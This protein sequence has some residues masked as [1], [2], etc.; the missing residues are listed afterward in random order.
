MTHGENIKVNIYDIKS[1]RNIAYSINDC[2][3]QILAFEM[4]ESFHIEV[5][6]AYA[7]MIRTYIMRK[8]HLFDGRGC[9]KYLKADLCNDPNHCIGFLPLDAI[10][11]DRKQELKQ[12]VEETANKIITF[13]GKMI[14]PYYHDTCGGATENSERIFGNIIQYA[15]RVLCDHC[16]STSPHWQ[17]SIEFTIEE[18]EEKLNIRFPKLSPFEGFAIDQ[19]LY[20]AERDQQGRIVQIKV[21]DQLIDG[22]DFQKRLGLPSTRIGW[23]P[24]GIK[25][26]IQG[27]GDGVGLCQYGAQGLALKGKN[28]EEILRYY[29]TGVKIEKKPQWSIKIPLKEKIILIDVGHGG[30]DLGIS[31]NG[32]LEKEM[33]FKISLLL[34]ECLD[35]AGAKA[36]LTRK[37]DEYISLEDRLHLSNHLQPHFMLSIHGNDSPTMSYV[38]QIYVYPGDIE[39]LEL[40]EYIIEWFKFLKIRCEDVI[41][42]ELYLTRESKKSTLVLDLGYFNIKNEEEINQ[43]VMAI[44]KGLL[45]YWGI[46]G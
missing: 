22:K 17:S 4:Q 3:V 46:I 6:K 25:F 45:S 12:A 18:L 34:K 23:Q 38:T 5:L 42:T 20:R 24:T 28:A 40:G 36:V 43:M 16:K 29:F 1:D 32:I 31:K 14:F 19:I 30:K 27:K 33:N 41:E 7:I 35:K 21:G 44:Y 13:Q 37:G 11:Q 10:T 26:F 8:M 39:A 15:R 9:N 2:I